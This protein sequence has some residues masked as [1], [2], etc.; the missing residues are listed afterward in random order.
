MI[1]LIVDFLDERLKRRKQQAYNN[2]YGWV[3]VEHFVNENSIYD[4]RLFIENGA[5]F[6]KTDFDRG[7][8]DAIRKLEE[9]SQRGCNNHAKK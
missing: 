4:I 1:Q 5:N 8:I 3:M 7:A 2:G 6:D 9:I